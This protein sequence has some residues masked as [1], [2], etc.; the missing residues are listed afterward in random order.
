MKTTHQPDAPHLSLHQRILLILAIML[1]AV[2]LR[3]ALSSISPIL[4]DIR[5]NIGLSISQAGILT[6]LPV[7]CLGLFAPLATIFSRRFTAERM[8]IPLLVLLA[9]GIALRGT[10]G[11]SGLFFGSFLSGLC[12]GM[13]GVL[14]PGIIKREFPQQATVMTGLYTMTL[15]LGAALAA[16]FSVPLMHAFDSLTISLA[17][18]ALPAILA[19]VLWWPFRKLGKY[20]QIPNENTSTSLWRD[21]L[22]WQVTIFMGLQS[23]LAYG[24]F[25]WL[26][27]ILQER[28]ATAADSGIYLS[29]SVMVQV[30]SALAVPWISSFL[31]D[32]K[33]IMTLMVV[34]IYLG[35]MGSVY[36]PVESVWLWMIIL[37][38]GQGGGFAMALSLIVLRTPNPV[39]AAQLS[40]MSQGV[41]YTMASLGP[42]FMGLIH[43]YTGSWQ[44]IGWLFSA[45]TLA[46]IYFGIQAGAN[47]FVLERK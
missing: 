10:L 23:S 13:I 45:I 1:V 38:L 18:W 24:V 46:G 26:P 16:G 12:I 11:I 19:A 22:A 34:L 14:L 40:G 9:T 20:S 36:A 5:L 31:H 2:N 37:G 39:M 30:F 21:S 7:A 28:G 15:C 25:G 41:G 29:V 47:R 27:S 8:L 4:T 44:S 32:Q 33:L 3:P 43:E 35:L 6:T 17:F 42:Y